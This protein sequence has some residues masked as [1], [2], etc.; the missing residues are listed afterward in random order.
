MATW[1]KENGDVNTL[2][3]PA[4]DAEI[5]STIVREKIKKGDDLSGLVD[6]EILLELLRR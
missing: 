6:E 1:N 3:I 5:S 4:E 2:L